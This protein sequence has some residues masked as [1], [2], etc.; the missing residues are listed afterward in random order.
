MSKRPALSLRARALQAL[1]LREH[2]RSEL[3]RKLLRKLQESEEEVESLDRLLDELQAQGLLSEARFIESRIHVRSPRFGNR[4]IQAEL[5]QH[6]L[7]LDEAS[8]EQLRQSELARA[9]AVWQRKFGAVAESPA[10]RAKQMR[11]LSGRGFSA[12]TIRRVVQGPPSLH[13]D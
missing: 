3:R 2:S 7:Q 13:E 1:A 6:G 12:E 8:A 4:R 5:A 9:L 10:E 11:F